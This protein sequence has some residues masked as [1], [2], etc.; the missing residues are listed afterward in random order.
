MLSSTET[1]LANRLDDAL[2]PLGATRPHDD[3]TFLNAVLVAVVVHTGLHQDLNANDEI[4]I[5]EYL[6][7]LLD[8]VSLSLKIWLITVVLIEEQSQF[9][10]TAMNQSL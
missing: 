3:D 2:A 4:I 5:M 7:T 1:V 10:S 6:L 8:F 9:L